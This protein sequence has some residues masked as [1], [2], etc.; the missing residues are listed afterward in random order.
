MLVFGVILA[1][2]SF[3]FVTMTS[4]TLRELVDRWGVLP[5]LE[6]TQ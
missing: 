1:A 2:V 3:I 6:V 5:P 4:I